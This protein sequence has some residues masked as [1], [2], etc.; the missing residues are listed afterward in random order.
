MVRDKLK[1]LGAPTTA[2][3]LGVTPESVVKAL[4]IAHTMRPERY[5]IL[6]SDGLTVEAAENLA[7]VTGVI[8]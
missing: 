6:G 7:R 2:D 1:T 4:T 5:T 8:D 3:E